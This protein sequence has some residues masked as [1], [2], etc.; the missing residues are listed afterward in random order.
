MHRLLAIIQNER[1]KVNIELCSTMKDGQ[2][3]V[4]LTLLCMAVGEDSIANRVKKLHYWHV[5]SRS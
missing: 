1:T 5:A 3:D 2:Q 4:F